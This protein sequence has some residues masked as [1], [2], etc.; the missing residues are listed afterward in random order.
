MKEPFSKKLPEYPWQL[1][2]P[3]RTPHVK[4]TEA[5]RKADFA[6]YQFDFWK[7]LL[8]EDL[9]DH[10]ELFWDEGPGFFR[11]SDGTFALSRER[12]NWPTLK[13]AGFFSEWGM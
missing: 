6:R 13:E 1:K 4:D 10:P 11:F 7:G 9:F 5:E 2:L 12:A 3:E 8:D